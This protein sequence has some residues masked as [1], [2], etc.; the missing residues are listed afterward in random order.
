[1][2]RLTIIGVTSVIS[3]LLKVIIALRGCLSPF[4]GPIPSGWAEYLLVVVL[5]LGVR[6][7]V[8][9]LL[10]GLEQRIRRCFDMRNYF[11]LLDATGSSRSFRPAQQDSS[12]TQQSQLAKELLLP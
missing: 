1:M 3:V 8:A 10:L 5:A 4:V 11:H 6:F 2:L 12:V 7:G 9:N